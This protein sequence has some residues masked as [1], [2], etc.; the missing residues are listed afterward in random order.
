MFTKDHSG[1][2][3]YDEYE[4]DRHP[5]Q[6]GPGYFNPDASKNQ[7]PDYMHPYG[8]G[9]NQ[10]PHPLEKNIPPEIYNVFGQPPQGVTGPFRIEHLLQQIQGADPNQGPL[11]PGQTPNV[12]LH[13]GQN[14]VN[15]NQFGPV[16]GGPPGQHQIAP[17]AAGSEFF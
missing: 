11:T 5:P 16:Q 14:A 2:Y 17:G 7:Y 10:Q 13:T 4:T 6:V 3:E 8:N 9:H 15:F 12:Y 1:K